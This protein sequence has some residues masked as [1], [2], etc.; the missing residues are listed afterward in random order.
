MIRIELDIVVDC[1]NLMQSTTAVTIERL[2]DRLIA[3]LIDS[4][5]H[6]DVHSG[7]PMP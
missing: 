6:S 2:I 7:G 5:V 4:D 3:H 1:G